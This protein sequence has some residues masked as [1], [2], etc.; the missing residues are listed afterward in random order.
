MCQLITFT[1]IDNCIFCTVNEEF[2]FNIETFLNDSIAVDDCVIIDFISGLCIP[3]VKDITFSA[4]AACQY[5]DG[6]AAGTFT[7]RRFRNIT[8]VSYE[9]DSAGFIQFCEFCPGHK[10]FINSRISCDLIIILIKPT[11]EVHSFRSFRII[12][13]KLGADFIIFING[14]NADEVVVDIKVNSCFVFCINSNG[15]IDH[16]IFSY[17][18]ST[19]AVPAP[20]VKSV[21]CGGV[22]ERS[23]CS[24]GFHR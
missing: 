22:R 13:D 18:T 11:L 20:K 9:E 2:D 4:V 16:C 21:S 8:I 6:C 23:D 5:T 24:A 3:S 19:V 15:F 10:R 14:N 12:R 7:L 17:F 1:R